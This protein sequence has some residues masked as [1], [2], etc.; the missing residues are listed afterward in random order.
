MIGRMHRLYV[1]FCGVLESGCVPHASLLILKAKQSAEGRIGTHQGR[2]RT[3]AQ[4]A[5]FGSKLLEIENH[6]TSVVA[7]KF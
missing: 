7:G 3:K 4:N 6:T 5:C 1:Y 2:V